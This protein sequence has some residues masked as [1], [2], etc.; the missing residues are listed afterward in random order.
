LSLERDTRVVTSPTKIEDSALV[1]RLEEE[2]GQLKKVVDI[3]N[4]EINNLKRKSQ[5]I[6]NSEAKEEDQNA[7]SLLKSIS[8]SNE[9]RNKFESNKKKEAYSKIRIEDIY[10]DEVSDDTDTIERLTELV[11]EYREQLEQRDKQISQ[12]NKVLGSYKQTIEKLELEGRSR[13]GSSSELRDRSKQ[14]ADMQALN[15]NVYVSN[16]LRKLSIAE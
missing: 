15:M 9:N 8:F 7:N 13:S 6:Q 4:A 2:N 3:L 11:N 5:A 10:E 14:A 16:I 1:R 12:L